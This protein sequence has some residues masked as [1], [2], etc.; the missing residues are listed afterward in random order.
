MK[1]IHTADIHLGSKMDSR[2]PKKISV[3]RK[4][5]LRGTF[6][7]M[8]DYA[9]KNDVRAIILAGDVFDSDTPT[10]KDKEF[11]YSVIR[12]T[13]D[14]DFLYLKGNHDIAAYAEEAISNLKT[15][16]NQWRYYDYGEVVVAGVESSEENAA[17]IYSTLSLSP[18]R[19]NI[20]VLHGQISDSTGKDKI[21]LKR[22]HDKNIDYL[23]LGHIHKQQSGKVDDRC[24]Y[25]YCGCLEGRGFDEIGE[26]GFYLLETGKKI[27]RRFIP[28]AER[29]ID[30]KSVDIS[31]ATDAYSAYSKV[32]QQIEFNEKDIYRINLVGELDSNVE[33]SEEE[34]A[35]LLSHERFFVDVKN[36]TTKKFD[37][38]EYEN[39]LSLKGEFVRT[40]FGSNGLS[41]E[42]KKRI[43]T[44]GLKALRGEDLEL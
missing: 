24:E 42:E 40:V 25:V 26:H 21:N 8:V 11:F 39:D 35:T 15:F 12:D 30:E 13:P 2:F 9:R 20:V 10:M 37:L 28:I 33:I 14:V 3:K 36:K 4:E 17:S 19:L 34:V 27:T 29:T 43:A 44:I 1:F 23:A 41:D 22:L 5:E 32:E 7:R 16:N 6:K 38:S 18:E 31:G